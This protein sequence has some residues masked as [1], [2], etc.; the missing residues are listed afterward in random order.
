MHGGGGDLGAGKLKSWGDGKLMSW[1]LPENPSYDLFTFRGSL[2]ACQRTQDRTALIHEKSIT[3]L[4]PIF[5]K[6]YSEISSKP[7]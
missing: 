6:E 7:C 3:G 5:I 1:H 2:R 4:Y